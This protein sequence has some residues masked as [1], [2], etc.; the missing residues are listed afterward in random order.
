MRETKR[1]LLEPWDE[2]HRPAWRL[3]CRDQEVMR[4][5]GLGQVWEAG[6]ADEVFDHALA[7]WQEHGFGWRSALDKATTAWIGF[8]GL[9]YVGRG[10]KGVAADE[11]EI[12]WWIVRLAWGRGYA[13]EGAAAIRDEGFERIGLDRIVARLQ[14]AN[15]RSAWVAEKIGM[16]LEKETTGR[17]GEALHIYALDRSSWS[18]QLQSDT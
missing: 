5:I 14:P 17:S 3:I 7:H 4:Y 8:V 6:K 13:S 10:T 15:V 16:S 12:G 11:V 1:L 9:N 18:R 2:R